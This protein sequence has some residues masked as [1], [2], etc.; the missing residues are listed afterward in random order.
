MH[1]ARNVSS[2]IL[3]KQI[4]RKPKKDNSEVFTRKDTFNIVSEERSRNNHVINDC[5]KKTE[6]FIEHYPLPSRLNGFN[7]DVVIPPYAVEQEPFEPHLVDTDQPELI[8]DFNFNDFGEICVPAFDK[9]DTVNGEM[10]LGENQIDF[11]QFNLMNSKQENIHKMK[12]FPPFPNFT[13]PAK[14]VLKNDMDSR[15]QRPFPKP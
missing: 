8:E 12:K 1:R 2:S 7:P 5:H 9:F 3:T 10:K 13:Y 15:L 4:K 6:E 11:N 14:P